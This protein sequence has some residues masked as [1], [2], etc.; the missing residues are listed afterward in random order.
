MPLIRPEIQQVLRQAGVLQ[1]K[2]QTSSSE[3]TLV[4]KLDAAGLSLEEILEELSTAAKTSGN[5]SLR[6]RAL[7]TALKAHGA[8]KETAPLPP[9]FT[10]I[11]DNS[12]STQQSSTLPLGV[13]PIL[14][15]RQLLNTLNNPTIETQTE[16]QAN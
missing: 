1:E 14:L 5:E 4:E 7:E 8:L 12:G 15:P 3:N 16:A 13:N 9:S 11:I 10:I 6:L 2:K